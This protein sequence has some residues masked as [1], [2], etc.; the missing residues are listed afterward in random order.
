ME[1][2]G[3]YIY[4]GLAE[5]SVLFV[6]YYRHPEISFAISNERLSLIME[7]A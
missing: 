1:N 4:C 6:L 2:Y 7:H 5:A 3:Y